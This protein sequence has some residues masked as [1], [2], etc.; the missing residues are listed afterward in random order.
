MGTWG[1]P[2][3]PHDEPPAAPQPSPV[4]GGSSEAWRC[5]G[6]AAWS[7]GIN[8]H[9]LAHIVLQPVKLHEPCGRRKGKEQRCCQP[10]ARSHR[11]RATRG[12]GSHRATGVGARVHGSPL[13]TLPS[14][15]AGIECP[16]GARNLPGLVQEGEPFSEEA[17]H[18]TKELVLQ[19][20]VGARGAGADDGRGCQLPRQ[21]AAG[22][23]SGWGLS[24]SWELPH[25]CVTECPRCWVWVWAQP[26]D[27]APAL[28]HG[29]GV[30]QGLRCPC[31]VLGVDKSPVPPPGT[32]RW[33]L[34]N[35]ALCWK[36]MRKF[37]RWRL[38]MTPKSPLVP[39]V[40][41]HWG[42]G[43]AGER[44][45]ASS[46]TFVFAWKAI[47]RAICAGHGTG[48]LHPAGCQVRVLSVPQKDRKGRGPK[49]HL[50]M[51]PAKKRKA[52]R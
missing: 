4:P 34:R 49:K 21:R 18:F 14:P 2:V 15:P 5:S 13:P 3:P 29:S 7:R 32:A 24:V 39:D 52:Q 27:A 20:E 33:C 50:A 42:Q 12:W 1:A 10:R 51:T 23:R 28:S 25:S 19:R 46:F 16:R 43:Q 30:V 26:G 8:F 40:S 45:L 35:G 38:P 48:G 11:P 44:S 9:F 17:T 6:C 22:R 41:P 31:C 37:W 47:T 36:P